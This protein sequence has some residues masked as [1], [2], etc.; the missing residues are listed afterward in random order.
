MSYPIGSFRSQPIEQLPS[1]GL[2]ELSAVWT[3]A[4]VTVLCAGHANLAYKPETMTQIRGALGRQLALGA[5]NAAVAGAACDWGQPCTYDLLFNSAGKR[6]TRLDIPSPFVI[7]AEP[8][9]KD[10]VV[11]VTLF[12]SA[13][14]R[15]AEVADALVRALRHGLDRA[16]NKLLPLDVLSRDIALAQGLPALPEGQPVQLTFLTPVV[17]RQDQ[18]AHADPASLILSLG[19]RVAGFAL[20]HGLRL[21]IDGPALREEATQLALAARWEEYGAL[22]WHSGSQAQGRRIPMA[23]LLGKLYLP[24]PM[25]TVAQ[26]LALGAWCHAGARSTKG[27]GRYTLDILSQ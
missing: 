5:S 1:L 2:T 24:A 7:A 3:M 4:R 8:H 20:W 10:L 26:L 21:E 25:Q 9:G 15:A 18:E 6:S 17:L 16:G 14:E 23:G 19:N 13:S 22:W 12:G 27:Q 11:I